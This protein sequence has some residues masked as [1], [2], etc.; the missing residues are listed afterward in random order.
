MEK[1]LTIICGKDGRP[2]M[3]GVYSKMENPS[4]LH[5]RRRLVKKKG[6]LEYFRKYVNHN[7]TKFDK[8]A[9]A[10]NDLTN[11]IVV[12]WG[13]TIQVNLDNSI[14]YNK[15]EAIT[16]ACNKKVSREVFEANGLN[17]PKLIPHIKN[18][19]MMI[20]KELFPIIAR[21]AKHSKGKN[22]IILKDLAS[23][24]NHMDNHPDWYYSAFVDKKQ[25]FR[26]HV[27]H[28]KILNYLEKPNPGAGKIAWNLAQN[29][30]AFENVKWDD[31]NTEICKL[32]IKAVSTLG[33]DFGAVD[34]MLT[35]DGKASLLEVN[36][37][38]TLASSE[39]S[40]S[41]YAKY[42]DWLCKTNTRREH[43]PIAEYKKASN[44]AWKDFNFEDRE[45]AK[46][47]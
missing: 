6:V 27:A 39:Y 24:K 41:R 19:N 22:F 1:K 2:S 4:E 31:Y 32:A 35:K 20:A 5:V 14:V 36:T 26:L 42:F 8:L 15:A 43:W 30:E 46:L 3:K 12:R 37:A 18:Q 9:I 44:Y 33:L 47:K 45:P 25:E 21:P 11:K 29:G 17:C 16:K 13:N 28:G 40:M 10:A 38:G 7:I 23:V 34:I